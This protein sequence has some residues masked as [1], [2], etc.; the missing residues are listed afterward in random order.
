MWPFGP[1]EECDG[2][3]HLIENT[4]ISDSLLTLMGSW[5]QGAW[6]NKRLYRVYFANVAK[7]SVVGFQVTDDG[8]TVPT[9]REDE[10]R[11]LTRVD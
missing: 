3:Y 5:K 9:V 8:E 2:L 11:L 10:S 6:N 7:T 4:I 1:D